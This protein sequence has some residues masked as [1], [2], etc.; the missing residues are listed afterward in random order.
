M[1]TAPTPTPSPAPPTKLQNILTIINAVLQGLSLIPGLGAVG[2]GIA[3][4]G[5]IEQVLQGILTSALAAY[6]QE[7]GKPID[8]TAIPQEALVP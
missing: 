6:Q 4:A 5:S 2:T 8:L 1:S 3:V 7:T